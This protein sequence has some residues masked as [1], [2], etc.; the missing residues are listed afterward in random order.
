MLEK[1]LFDYVQKLLET[2]NLNISNTQKDLKVI[3]VALQSRYPTSP[4]QQKIAWEVNKK[5]LSLIL[6]WLEQNNEPGLP[7]RKPEYRTSEA[8]RFFAALIENLDETESGLEQTFETKIQSL[9]ERRLVNLKEWRQ[10]FWRLEPNIHYA[11]SRIMQTQAYNA[12]LEASDID[13]AIAEKYDAILLFFDPTKAGHASFK[14]YAVSVIYRHLL[15]KLRKLAPI[16][17]QIKHSEDENSDT[18]ELEAT[19]D[20][21]DTTQINIAQA[22]REVCRITLREI[23]AEGPDGSRLSSTRQTLLYLEL[24]EIVNSSQYDG[25]ITLEAAQLLLTLLQPKNDSNYDSYVLFVLKLQTILTN[26][27]K[28]SLQTMYLELKLGNKITAN[29]VQLS[30]ARRILATRPKLRSAVN[31]FL[32][33]TPYQTIYQQRLKENPIKVVEYCFKHVSSLQV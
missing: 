23:G 1:V 17:L 3:L 33:T 30:Q 27:Q 19:Y 18:N 29:R 13:L 5:V 15:D 12:G 20:K 7:W 16:E 32:T 4:K 11:L 26:R 25:F 6:D 2:Y 31:S 14:T 21:S 10:E 9:L 28:I 22:I 8:L 24:L